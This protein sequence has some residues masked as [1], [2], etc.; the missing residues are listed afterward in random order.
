ML[1]GWTRGSVTRGVTSAVQGWVCAKLSGVRLCNVFECQ[2][3][4]FKCQIVFTN[5]KSHFYPCIWIS[6]VRIYFMSI[7]KLLQAVSDWYKYFSEWKKCFSYKTLELGA[8]KK[9]HLLRTFCVKFFINILKM[10]GLVAAD[11]TVVKSDTRWVNKAEKLPVKLPLFYC[12]FKF[13]F[14]CN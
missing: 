11:L 13:N 6:Y 3:V 9:Y 8:E 5:R 10:N 2:K 1:Q 14:I 7:F 4:M 12:D